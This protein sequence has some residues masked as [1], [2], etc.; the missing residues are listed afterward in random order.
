ML[1]A[2]FYVARPLLLASNLTESRKWAAPM[3]MASRLQDETWMG[4]TKSVTARFPGSDLHSQ[5]EVDRPR[6][7]EGPRPYAN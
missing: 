4:V 5:V 2:D 6:K 1:S 7:G 3:R